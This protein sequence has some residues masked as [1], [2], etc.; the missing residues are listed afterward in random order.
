MK[1]LKYI[2]QQMGMLIGMI[3]FLF[4][5]INILII[6]SMVPLKDACIQLKAK[7]LALQSKLAQYRKLSQ[8]LTEAKGKARLDLA[9]TLFPVISSARSYFIKNN[10]KDIADTINYT[11]KELMRMP[12]QDLLSLTL[13]A[14]QEIQPELSRLTAY[15]ITATSLDTINAKYQ[16]LWDLMSSRTQA[17]TRRHNL[18]V[19]ITE[20]MGAIMNMF[21]NEL[22]PLIGNFANTQPDFY[23]DF[24]KNKRVGQPHT[25]H[26]R[27]MAHV[28]TEIGTPYYGLTVTVDAFT[29]PDT[30][31]TYKASS[32]VT[33]DEGNAEV[34]EFFAGP[35][36][37]TISGSTVITQTFAAITFSKGK[38]TNME[39]VMQPAF[40]LPAPATKQ[41]T[42]A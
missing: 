6:N 16:I 22:T 10:R 30:G 19:T 38:S 25:T 17:E 9:A 15:G 36:T 13:L 26:T 3:A 24:Q 34:S 5:P 33:N 37:V 35:R 28:S 1:K 14:V 32:A 41:K 8:A 29:D 4:N 39:F 31:K 42:N 12:F 18:G 11:L 2:N 27:L 20:D 7:V 40:T 21:H 23:N